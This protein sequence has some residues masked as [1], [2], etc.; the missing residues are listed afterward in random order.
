[1]TTSIAPSTAMISIAGPAQHPS[2][3]QEPTN[4]QIAPTN[5][6]RTHLTDAPR[7]ALDGALARRKLEAQAVGRPLSRG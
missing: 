4:N 1:M 2:N 6:A 3:T 5:R 7:F